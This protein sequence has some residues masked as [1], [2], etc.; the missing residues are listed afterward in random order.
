MCTDLLNA[1]AESGP[2][3]FLDLPIVRYFK[4]HGKNTAFRK[5]E[6]F[7]SSSERWEKPGPFGSL[8]IHSG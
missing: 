1:L 3:G 4:E 8:D 2:V 7:P 6:L 5:L